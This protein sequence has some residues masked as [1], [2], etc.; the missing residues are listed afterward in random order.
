MHIPRYWARSD[1]Q[2]PVKARRRS[3]QFVCWGWSDQSAADAKRNADARASAVGQKFS[4]G[5]PLDK[6]P[7]GLGDRPLRE[8]VVQL[9]HGAARDGSAVITRNQ[10]G[11]LVL[12][13]AK[14]MFID[15]DFD[16][17]VQVP[18]SGGF[19][20][21]L[22]AR[23]PTP[24]ELQKLSL[25]K[26]RAWATQH[27]DK[28]LRLYRTYAGFRCLVTSRTFEAASSESME[29][30]RSIGSDPLYV[31]LCEA[32]ACFRARLTP[33]PWRC[34]VDRPPGS[35]PRLDPQMELRFQQWKREYEITIQEYGVC[36]F[37]EQIG[38]GAH[39]P[40]IVPILQLHDR[41]TLASEKPL[42]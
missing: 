9:D 15:L 30:L 33:K 36:R 32:Q 1:P 16:S 23:K 42:A 18:K 31:R 29:L 39:H 11:V 3:I 7:Y 2:Q 25:E 26:I 28:G 5:N 35:F 40:E 6:Y 13:A 37:I 38:P 14:A 4:A 41:F 12:N 21:R 22:F 17:Y 8:E 20:S 19:F 24:E 34:A 10:Y 27:R